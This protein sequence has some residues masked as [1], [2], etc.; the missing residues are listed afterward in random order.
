M[1][2]C[3]LGRTD[4]TFKITWGSGTRLIIRPNLDDSEPSVYQL[5]SKK[6]SSDLAACLI[7]DYSPNPINV[8]FNGG[9]KPETTNGSTVVVKDGDK[10]SASLGVVIW[11]KNKDQ[12]QCSATYNGQTY[13]AEKEGDATCSETL[14]ETPVFET[15]ERLNLLSL[16]VLGLRLIFFKSVALN[17]ILTYWAWSR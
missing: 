12:F 5:E 3:A 2:F 4:N 9:L 10:E 13:K 7:T 11:T 8:M 17:L 15:D 16:T 1:Y 6:E 14:S